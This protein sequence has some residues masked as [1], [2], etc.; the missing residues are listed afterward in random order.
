MCVCDVCVVCLYVCGLC[1]FVHGDRKTKIPSLLYE[2]A[3]ADVAQYH[4]LGGLNSRN[5]LPHSS[6]GWSPNQCLQNWFLLR[7]VREVLCLPVSSFW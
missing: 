4:E 1:V 3:R 5:V 2:F 6:G 7:A